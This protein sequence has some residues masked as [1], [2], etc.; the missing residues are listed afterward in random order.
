MKKALFLDRDGV[1]NQD[2]GY[3]HTVADFD[4]IPGIFKFCQS[5]MALGYSLFVVTNQSGIGR[6]YY[7]ECT[8]HDL[9]DWMCIE[10]EKQGI[11]I[12]KVYYCPHHP[13]KAFGHYLTH[14]QCRKPNA[15]MI[16]QAIKEFNLSPKHCILIGD[17]PSDLAAAK[18]AGIKGIQVLS[19]QPDFNRLITELELFGSIS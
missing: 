13:T 7:S 11:K 9:T 2:K 3:V 16:T 5:A 10:F 18:N 1:I 8:F 4:F 15:G 17:N 14:C 19:N 12:H 6:G